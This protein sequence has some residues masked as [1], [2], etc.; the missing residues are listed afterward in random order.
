VFVVIVHGK[1]AMR[2][3]FVAAMMHLVAISCAI[4]LLL[5]LEEVYMTKGVRARWRRP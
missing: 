3:C 4:D 1:Y 5:L 2:T